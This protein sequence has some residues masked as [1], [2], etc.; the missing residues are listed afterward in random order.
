MMMKRR[1]SD[2]A[3]TEDEQGDR[4][5]VGRWTE[6]SEPWW[7]DRRT[8]EGPNVVIVV[9]DDVGY[10]DFGCYGSEIATPT[11]DSLASHGLRYTNFHTTGLCSPTRACL[12]TGRNHHSVGMGALADWDSGFPGY[13][14]RISHSCATLSEMLQPAGYSTWAVGK[15]H[16]TPASETS[17]VGPFGQWPTQRGFDRFYGFLGAETNQYHPDLVEDNHRLAVPNS[18]TYHLSE[19]LVDHSIS[20]LSEHISLARERPFFLYLAFA[21]CHAPHQVW[22]PY[23]DKYEEV[24]SKGWDRCRDDRLARQKEMGI[25]PEST[26][27]SPRNEDVLPWDELT[28]DQQRLFV[29]LQAAYAGFLEHTDEQLGRLISFMEAHDLINST[30]MAVLSDNGASPEGS[31]IGTVNAMRRLN[32]LDDDLSYN[33]EHYDEI[34]QS[35]LNNNY[36]LGWAMAGNTPLKRY[37]QFSHGGGVRDPLVLSWPNGI[38]VCGELRHQFHHASDIVPTILEI[39]G[40]QPPKVVKGV[41]QLPIEG[42]SMT[43]TFG[44]PTARSAKRVQYFEVLGSRGIWHDGWKAV[45]WHK[46]GSAFSEDIWELYNL[47]QDFSECNNLATLEPERLGELV[48]LWWAAA[49]RHQVLPLRDPL[50]GIS[51]YGGNPASR[52]VRYELLPG[53]SRIPTD[54]APDVRN[55]SFRILADLEVASPGV[56]GVILAHG[57]SC[58]GYALYCE[59]GIVVFEVNFVGLHSL[60]RS[61]SALPLGHHRLTFSFTSRSTGGGMGRMFCDDMALGEADFTHGPGLLV[62]F[63]SFNLGEAL[64]PAVGQF[65]AP[66]PFSGTLKRLV[67]E[68]GEITGR[69][70]PEAILDGALGSQ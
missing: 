28:A 36:P 15:W 46:R 27:L 23:I 60:M 32:R 61:A 68:L 2:I 58:G 33:L 10:S 63:A 30:V 13:R 50:S 35:H 4:A 12:L 41:A 5:I 47:D 25:V 57:D 7:P 67:I 22:K 18:P 56:S 19:D 52:P 1:S 49:G 38:D 48:D 31:P 37:K 45:V 53:I 34:G 66:S 64:V 43:Y 70:S 21:A 20:L 3:M 42:E 55:R 39:V 6:E 26:L 40:V 24:F 44:A 69:L 54:V 65:Q 14:G 16:L 59:E 29:R 51:W 62:N 11:I 8:V 9:L 17:A